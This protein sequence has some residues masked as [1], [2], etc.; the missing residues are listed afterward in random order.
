MSEAI[1]IHEIVRNMYGFDLEQEVDRLMR[2]GQLPAD[3]LLRISHIPAQ[4]TDPATGELVRPQI[5]RQIIDGT[6]EIP[7]MPDVMLNFQGYDFHELSGITAHLP[8]PV[9]SKTDMAEAIKNRRAEFG[10]TI[11]YPIHDKFF[12]RSENSVC[13]GLAHA[14]WRS[15]LTRAHLEWLADDAVEQF[16]VP[17]LT[18]ASAGNGGTHY[19]IDMGEEAKT[20]RRKLVA[21]ALFSDTLLMELLDEAKRTG[22]RGIGKIAVLDLEVMLSE[23]HPELNP[24]VA[25]PEE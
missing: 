11:P 12:Y 2:D 3:T 5:L 9:Y 24:F 21:S 10:E 4:L 17:T 18:Q 19:H 22:I 20:M 6:Y 23:Q 13:K 1:G 7:E 16:W 8:G 15:L 14:V 25:K